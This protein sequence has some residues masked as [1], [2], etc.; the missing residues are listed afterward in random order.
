[1]GPVTEPT[2]SPGG[3]P[4]WRRPDRRLLQVRRALVLLL[5]TLPGLVGAAALALLL[6]PAEAVAALVTTT[7][8]TGLLLVA[9]ER[10]FAAWGYLEREDDLLVRRGVLVR[11][12]SV[13][14]YGRMQYVDVTAGPLDRRMG[15]ATVTLHT[16][17]AATDASVPGLLAPEAARLRDR[18]AALGE[19]RQAGV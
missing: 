9:V 8:V 13:V 18:L 6:G 1:L 19:A 4:A 7:A 16:A 15:L 11:R 14:P 5:V 3:G 2:A 10:R 17:A 12:T